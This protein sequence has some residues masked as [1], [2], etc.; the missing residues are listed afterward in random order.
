V[1]G[2]VLQLKRCSLPLSTAGVVTE[3][4]CWGRRAGERSS[5]IQLLVPR[6]GFF[7]LGSRGWKAF[8]KD[9]QVGRIGNM[10]FDGIQCLSH[11]GSGRHKRW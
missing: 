1:L 5:C 7:E 4:E 6:I 9:D 2:V 3:E 8:G 11:P 10:M